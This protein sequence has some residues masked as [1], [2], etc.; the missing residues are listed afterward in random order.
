MRAIGSPIAVRQVR[1]WSDTAALLL[2]GAAVV[3]LLTLGALLA[4][5]HRMLIVR[6]GSMSPAI[7]A[8]DV[9]VT[10][11]VGPTDV[12]VGDVVT[13]RD[14]SRDGELITHRLVNVH[15]AGG[16]SFR[17]QTRGDANTGSEEW[18]IA[19]D[20]RLGKLWF[21]LPKAGYPLAWAGD[22]RVRAVLLIG[23]AM[24]LG[25]AAVRRIWT[26]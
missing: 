9:V 20:G 17:F 25:F 10:T 7:N 2:L 5:G 14:P 11:M 3:M 15:A 18:S 16:D 22:A 4:S 23:G 6:S 8:G 13:F 26:G 19:R 24:F 21:T 12:V 1:R